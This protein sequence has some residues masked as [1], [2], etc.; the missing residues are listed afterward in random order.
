MALQP[1]TFRARAVEGA[2]GETEGG[3]PQIAI[4]LQV[5]DEGFAGETITW[6]GY[7]SEKTLKRTFE[8]LR[9][10][11]WKGDDLTSLD[12]ITDNEVKIVVIEDTYEGKT[13]LKV[14]WINR[15]GGLALKTPM[16]PD[17]V[18]SFAAEMRGEA[19]ASR[20]GKPA[21]TAKPRAATSPA[22][23]QSPEAQRGD[24]PLP[25]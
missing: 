22:A 1:G 6:F 23:D 21:Q 9:I 18:K 2:M 4:E 13:R 19:V 17:R 25:F 11:G 12:G 24:D 5:L 14:N 16:S 10:L 7:F 15:P 3:K 20:Q 8:S